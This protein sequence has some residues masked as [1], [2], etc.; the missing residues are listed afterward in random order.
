MNPK[1]A[2]E[3]H[4]ARYSMYDNTYKR[5]LGPH[6]EWEA[7]MWSDELS[8]RLNVARIYFNRKTREAFKFMRLG[9]FQTVERVTGQKLRLKPFDLKGLMGVLLTDGCVAQALGLGDAL[10]ELIDPADR[11]HANTAEDIIKYIL[12]IC[13]VHAHRAR[14]H[15]Q[16]KA[17]QIELARKLCM[18]P[19][20]HNNDQNLYMNNG[21][22]A[23]KRL[24]KIVIVTLEKKM[25][26][27]IDAAMADHR[28]MIKELTQR[29]QAINGG[30][31]PLEDV[32][33]P[34][35][36]DTDLHMPPPPSL[37]MAEATTDAHRPR[38]GS[39]LV[40]IDSGESTDARETAHAASPTPTIFVWTQEQK[41]NR[42]VLTED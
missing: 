40:T 35:E 17:M 39:R 25:V 33:Q 31:I 1:L 29:K 4:S 19:N 38:D 10:L 32:T 28:S 42:S 20:P 21:S 6:N 13:W 30:R 15:D 8:M 34:A 37:E 41:G 12:R 18:A 5:V 7:A 11:P 23:V 9:N 2:Q 16:H 14:I 24:K 26:A 22:R 3:L 27:K 36:V